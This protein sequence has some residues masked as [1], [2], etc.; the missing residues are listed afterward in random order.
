MKQLITTLAITLLSGCSV[1][2]A[3][4][5]THYD[6][7]E[8]Q[9]IT[10]IRA[11]AQQ[12]KTQCDDASVSKSNAAKLATDTQLFVL[13]SEHVPRNT[14]VISAS[15]DLHLLAQGLVDQYTKSD[16]VSPGF[17]KIKFSNV[18]T[19]ADKMQQVIARRPR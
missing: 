8:Y 3:Y 14:D 6:P 10:S 7:N 11:E 13:Y 12:F 2:D 4:L 19:S 15:K 18:E 9:L 1:L 17:C 16:K 5:M